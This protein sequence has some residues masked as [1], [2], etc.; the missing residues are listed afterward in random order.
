MLSSLCSNLTT[1]REHCSAYLNLHD[2]VLFSYRAAPIAI[3]PFD[4]MQKPT[5]SPIAHAAPKAMERAML[6]LI[7]PI[8]RMLPTII[9]KISLVLSCSSQKME[10]LPWSYCLLSITV[11]TFRLTS[12]TLC[13]STSYQRRP[14]SSCIFDNPYVHSFLVFLQGTKNIS[15][16]IHAWSVSKLDGTLPPINCKIICQVIRESFKMIRKF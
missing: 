6:A 4:P 8:S 12:S 13:V 16:S 15:N 3:K 14:N 9:L 10:Y 11:V 7:P 2:M 1:E 5:K